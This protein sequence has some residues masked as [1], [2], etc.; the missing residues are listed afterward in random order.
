MADQG[1]LFLTDPEGSVLQLHWF[2]TSVV[3]PIIFFVALV[4]LLFHVGLIQ[5]FIGKF[6]IFSFGV[7]VF[8]APRPSSRLR[9]PS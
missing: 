4:S 8:R 6:A 7:F 1:V 9:L 2:L 5:W 3:P